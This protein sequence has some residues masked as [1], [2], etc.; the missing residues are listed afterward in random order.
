MANAGSI[1]ISGFNNN[2][3]F[4]NDD[5]ADAAQDT[6]DGKTTASAAAGAANS[7]AKTDGT[8]G[9]W[10]LNS[11]SLT[12]GSGVHIKSGQTAYNSG[13]GFYLG[14]DS[15]TP[16]FSIGNAGTNAITWDGS[17]MTIRGTLQLA[18]GTAP[19]ANQTD[20]EA[21]VAS[22]AGANSQVKTGG[23]VGGWSLSSSTISS[24]NITLDNTNARIL[25]ED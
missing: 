22:N 18:S 19:T 5:A 17:T 11:T 8:V 2:S 12:G 15:G 4:T 1:N 25:I 14:N 16:K 6:A 9:G 3:G 21:L 24:T 13:T 23:S 7:A 10:T 20:A